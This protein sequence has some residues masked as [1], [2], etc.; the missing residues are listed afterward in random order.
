MHT[1]NIGYSDSEPIG[2]V[3]TL[4]PRFHAMLDILISQPIATAANPIRTHFPRLASTMIVMKFGGSSVADATQIEKV[5]QIVSA[6]A[7]KKPVVVSSAHKGMTN[8]LIDAAKAAA[9]GVYNPD[10]VINL[11]QGV[12]TGLGCPKD[13]LA[14]FYHEIR[15]LLRGISLVREITPR[16]IDYVASFGERMAVRCIADYFSRH[17]LMARAYDIWDLGFTTDSNFGEARPV[18]GFESAMRTAMTQKVPVG[19]VPIITGFV[20]KDANGA[21][22]TVGRNGSDFTATL[23][24]AAL[25]ADEVEIWTD[26]DG[27]MTADPRIV[28][29]ALNIPAMTF[30]EAAELAYFGSRVLH[31]ATLVPAIQRK[32][33]VRVLNTNRADHPGTV[34]FE[35]M[36]TQPGGEVT[37]IAHKR[38]QTVLTIVSARMFGTAGFLSRVFEVIGRHKVVIDMVSTSEVSVSMTTDSHEN[39]NAAIRELDQFGKC[40]VETDKAILCV[41]GRRLSMAQ[42]IGARILNAIN[43]VGVNIEMISHGQR[44]INLSVLIDEREVERVVTELHQELFGGGKL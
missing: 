36:S 11:Q 40:T 29:N 33:P 31:P 5:R 21:I 34:I 20:G 41:V 14:D 32:I 27:V 23:V 25:N 13:M 30:S 16:S 19:V 8:A 10:P 2:A 1:G 12:L 37:S 18:S 3:S 9:K 7:A 42:G 4:L 24:G 17:Q 6:K 43:R 38:G 28:P 35:D 26:T 44:S 15:D 22:T 39:M